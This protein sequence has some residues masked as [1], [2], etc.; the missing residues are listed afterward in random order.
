MR[1]VEEE[2]SK[3]RR[4][5]RWQERPSEQARG[6]GW[7]PC[8]VMDRS[9]G[10]GSVWSSCWGKQRGDLTGLMGIQMR[11]NSQLNNP[12]NPLN[13]PPPG[14]EGE[15]SY[16]L[17]GIEAFQ[18]NLKNFV[19]QTCSGH[20]NTKP[21]KEQHK[22]PT[23][24]IGCCSVCIVK[25]RFGGRRPTIFYWAQKP[26]QPLKEAAVDKPSRRGK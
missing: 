23:L 25:I 1:G 14:K 18:L 8:K 21:S 13:S 24:K 4:A 6:R 12:A 11:L 26:Q 19:L 16:L 10:N 17:M 9:R 20:D 5:R 22:I 15:L 3:N 7:C 2:E